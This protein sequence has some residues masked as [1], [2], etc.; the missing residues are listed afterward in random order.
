MLLITLP[1]NE[2]NSYCVGGR[3]RSG[4]TNIYDDITS[5][6]FKVLTKEVQYVIEKNLSLLV[7]TQKQQKVWLISSST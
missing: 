1:K 7:L 5:K 6:G 2:R 4:T 3:H